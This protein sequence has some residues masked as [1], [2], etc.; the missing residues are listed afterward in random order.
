M[1]Q[2]LNNDVSLSKSYKKI[3]LTGVIF[4]AIS[5]IL[6][7][8]IINYVDYKRESNNLEREYLANKKSLIKQEVLRTS[9][10]INNLQDNAKKEINA[11]IKAK[12][13]NA[14]SIDERILNINRNLQKIAL[15]YIKQV[16]FGSNSYIF[17]VSYSGT[18]IMNVSQPHLIG[19]NIWNLEDPNGFKVIQ[20]ERKAVENP[21]GDFIYYVWNK[22]A[23][24][25]PSPKVSFMYGIQDWQWMIGAG[26]YIDDVNKEIITLKENL[27]QKLIIRLIISLAIASIIALF[28]IYLINRVTSAFD[29]KIR[30]FTHVFNKYQNELKKI[31]ADELKYSELKTIAT[32]ANNMLSAR[33]KAEKQQQLLISSLAKSEAIFRGVLENDIHGVLLLN[34]QGIIILANTKVLEMTG[35]KRGELVGEFVEKLIAEQF[36]HH[37]AQQ[38]KDFS[39]KHQSRFMGTGLDIS[40]LCKN[41][42]EIPVDISLTSINTT[43]GYFVSAVIDDISERVKDKEKLIYQATFDTLTQLPNR[44]LIKDRLNQLIIEAKRN[45]KLAA[46]IYI[47]IDDFKKI[48]DTLGHEAGDQILIQASNRLKDITRD[49]DTVGRL[50][51]DEFIILLGNLIES[52]DVSSV[53]ESLINK[54]REVFHIDGYNLI[55]TLSIGIALYPID[56]ESDSELLR[57]ADSAMYYSKKIGRNTYSYFSKEMNK[58]GARRLAIEEQMYE[59]LNRQEFEVYYQPQINLVSN[60]IIGAEALLRWKNP[61]LGFISPDEFIPIAEKTG[62]IVPIGYFVLSQ[63]LEATK[64]WHQS[65]KDDFRIAINLS[66]R[67]FRESDFLTTIDSIIKQQGVPREFIEL[68]ITEGIFMDGNSNIDAMLQ[69]MSNSGISIAMDDFGTGYSS[70]SYLRN[71]PFDVIKVDRIFISEMD[72]NIADKNL[73]YASIRMAHALSLEVVAEGVETDEQCQL[74]K[75][76]NCDIGQGYLFSKP[77]TKAQMEALLSSSYIY[78]HRG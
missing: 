18:T 35:Y 25:T 63:A 74:L 10:Y 77:I 6:S 34:A 64:Q 71:Y 2:P 45:N 3:A 8:T 52:E 70:L 12:T 16:K 54:F 7:I 41:G 56:G 27:K 61:K 1:K 69:K 13:F 20:A 68:E 4:T 36:H 24:S 51:G 38:R 50:G 15:D 40:M 31:E 72:T 65:F 26:V 39:E 73:T 62:L 78:K 48:N 66:P 5:F 60:K 43:D 67:Q 28:I 29:R 37:H 17:V 59:A 55:A 30:Q 53:A 11:L 22:P 19:K 47:D 21:E 42:N 76:M 75:A 58:A 9:S 33:N 14:N 32:A 23:T 46:I 57:N 49:C 44:F